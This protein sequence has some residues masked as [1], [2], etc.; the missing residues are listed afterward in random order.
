MRPNFTR[1]IG[2]HTMATVRVNFHVHKEMFEWMVEKLSSQPNPLSIPQAENASMRMI[3]EAFWARGNGIG[4]WWF[5]VHDTRMGG[6]CFEHCDTDL[7]ENEE[8]W[9]MK[10]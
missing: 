7:G 6:I 2:G 9:E 1:R 5:P 10:E 8:R 3:K 4:E